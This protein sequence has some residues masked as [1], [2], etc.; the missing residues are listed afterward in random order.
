VERLDRNGDG[1]V[2]RDEF[3]GPPEHFNH[4]DRNGDGYITGDE[5]AQG[6]PPRRR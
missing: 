4:F 5:A 3:D 2:S 1:R 6:P